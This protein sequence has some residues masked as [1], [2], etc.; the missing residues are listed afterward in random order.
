MLAGYDFGGVGFA[1]EVA[2]GVVVAFDLFDCFVGGDD[3]V[4]QHLSIRGRHEIPS[5]L[6]NPGTRFQLA[7]KE[8]TERRKR[9]ERGVEFIQVCVEQAGVE[10]VDW[11]AEGGGDVEGG[12]VA[13][14]PREEAEGEGCVELDLSITT[15]IKGSIK[16]I[17]IEGLNWIS[18]K[19]VVEKQEIVRTLQNSSIQASKVLS[20]L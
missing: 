8:I 16:R 3:S 18:I 11:S 10:G 20:S 2:E 1:D 14:E 9:V 12:E 7:V 6:G 17:R 4:V 5:F 19:G 13:P 15:R